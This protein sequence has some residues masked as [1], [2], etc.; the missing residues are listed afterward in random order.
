MDLVRAEVGN[1]VFVRLWCSWYKS[2]VFRRQALAHLL[3]RE[4]HILAIG[5]SQQAIFGQLC[6]HYYRLSVSLQRWVRELAVAHK[7]GI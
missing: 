4:I 2:F 5:D 6:N 3:V 1:L 7:E